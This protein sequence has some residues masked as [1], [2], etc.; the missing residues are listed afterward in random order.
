MKIVKGNGDGGISNPSMQTFSLVLMWQHSVHVLLLPETQSASD[1]MGYRGSD[2]Q[3][4]R[5][6]TIISEKI[7]TQIH[8]NKGKNLSQSLTRYE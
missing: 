4:K 7:L 1:N 5:R 8:T 3:R 2:R 6:S